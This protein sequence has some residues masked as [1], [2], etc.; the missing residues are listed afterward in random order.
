M[1]I[2]SKAAAVTMAI[3]ASLALAASTFAAGPW[4]LFG[5]ATNEKLG[6]S[7][8]PWAVQ[9]V[10]DTN[11]LG[12]SND[13]SGVDFV[14]PGPDITFNEL[15]VLATDYNL[16]DD[17]AGGGSPRFQLNM[18]TDGDGVSDGNV[19]VYIGTP[20]AFAD[21]P[22]GWQSSGN[23]VESTDLRYDSTQFGGPFYGTHDG[24]AA[25][26]GDDDIVGIQLV[27]D[28]G[29][30]FGDQEQTVLVD[31]VIVNNHKLTAK[32]AK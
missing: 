5:G 16:T 25:L 19:F 7:P 6:Q 20:P 15:E 8:N 22:A 10:S 3:G 26:V 29:W 13:Y 23:L 27:V 31:N 24:T 18:D 12:D 17:G 4:S 32:S 28:S 2:V 1:K 21:A 14:M 30:F 11:T 9:L